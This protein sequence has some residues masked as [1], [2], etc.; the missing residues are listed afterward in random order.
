MK[1]ILNADVKGSGKKGDIINVSDGYARNFL[2]PRKLATE[3][4]AANLN[5]VKIA[6]AALQHRKEV[7]KA[8]AV[9]LGE[10]LKKEVLTVK[11]KCGD[12]TRLFGAIT[13]AEI[14]AAIKET[15]GIDVDKK[16]IVINEPIKE[17]GSYT[18]TVKVYAEVAVP[19]KINVIKK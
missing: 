17:L 3:A 7:A 14:A 9:E 5:A 8:E 16:K 4:N 2:F 18:V 1:V 6:D 13:N 11:G 15:Y 10:K 12:G 19:V